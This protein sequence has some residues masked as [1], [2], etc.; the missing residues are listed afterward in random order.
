MRQAA[1]LADAIQLAEV[2]EGTEKA[3]KDGFSFLK[4][5]LLPSTIKKNKKARLVLVYCTSVG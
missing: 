4:V 5:S 1:P 3:S 2:G